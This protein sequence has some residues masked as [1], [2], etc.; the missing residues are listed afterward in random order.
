[1][2]SSIARADGEAV[3][4]RLPEQ[5]M[6]EISGYTLTFGIKSL[7]RQARGYFLPVAMN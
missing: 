5:F 3:V 4:G 6:L 1:M 7:F 2:F